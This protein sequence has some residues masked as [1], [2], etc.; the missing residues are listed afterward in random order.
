MAGWNVLRDNFFWNLLEKPHEDSRSWSIGLIDYKKYKIVSIGSLGMSM[1]SKNRSISWSYR[2]VFKYLLI[3]RKLNRDSTIS[4]CSLNS[5]NF[6]MNR[7]IQ[8]YIPHNLASNLHASH[9]FLFQIF[10]LRGNVRI[11]ELIVSLLV[12]MRRNS[13]TDWMS[14]LL[15]KI[16]HW[17]HSLP[18]HI[19]ICSL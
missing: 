6:Q 15:H 10:Y 16:E 8:S 3:R 17:K 14:W 9:K 18:R 5:S 12:K 2:W 4:N 19:Q 1:N 7:M 11:V 13:E